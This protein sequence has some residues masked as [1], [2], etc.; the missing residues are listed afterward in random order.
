MYALQVLEDPLPHV[1]AMPLEDNLLIWHG[2][3]ELLSECMFAPLYIAVSSSPTLLVTVRGDP[4]QPEHPFSN[5]PFH[6][7]LLFPKDYPTKAPEVQLY[8]NFPH[9]NVRRSHAPLR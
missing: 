8:T 7:L 6:F 1:V 2:N 3:G 9:P 5:V 4:D